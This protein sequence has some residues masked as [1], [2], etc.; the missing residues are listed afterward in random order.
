VKAVVVYESMYGNTHL[1]AEA[2]ANGLRTTDDDVVVVPVGEATNQLVADADLVVVGGPT[3]AHGM[4]RE[5]SRKA[6]VDA[7]RKGGNALELDPDA[8]GA[9]LRDWFDGLSE[10][11]T[12]AAAFDTRL[13]APAVFT[14]RASKGI[15]KRLRGH[16]STLVVEPMSFLVT[17]QSQLIDDEATHAR[18]WGA[19]IRQALTAD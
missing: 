18:E 5:N 11:R 17:K 13:D 7:T 4:S 19:Q 1:I 15:A 2:I 10:L 3:H 9:G 14:G 8:Q 6:A 12:N 16:G